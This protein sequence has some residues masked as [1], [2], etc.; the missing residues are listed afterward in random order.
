MVA[1]V[2]TNALSS[3]TGVIKLP[4]GVK[5]ESDAANSFERPHT[6]GEVV[7]VVDVSTYDAGVPVTSTTE[8]S[9]ALTVS[10]TPV[11][12]NSMILVDFWSTMMYGAA[13]AL[14]GALY[15]KVG[16]DAYSNLTPVQGAAARYYYG[17]F[18]H[19]IPYRAVRNRYRDFPLSTS[20]ITYRLN[21]RNWSSTATNYVAYPY[22]E[23]GWSVMEIKQ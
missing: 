17:W 1:T 23:Y 21:Y 11:Y 20:E 12:S 5:I 18:Y 15:R 19:A 9:L 13:N 3:P 6:M 7:Q 16:D 22:M 8:V 2:K 10:I 4:A 14:V